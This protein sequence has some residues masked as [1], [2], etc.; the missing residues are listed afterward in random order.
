MLKTGPQAQPH[1]PEFKVGAT[2]CQLY[3]FVLPVH[4]TMQNDY[5]NIF[6]DLIYEAQNHDTEN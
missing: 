6:D 5:A 2:A 4:T 1:F 3:L